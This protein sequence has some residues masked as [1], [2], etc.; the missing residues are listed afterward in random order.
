MLKSDVALTGGGQTIYELAATAT[1]AAAIEIA[2]NQRRNAE[3]FSKRN[4][5]SLV[6]R[7]DERDVIEKAVDAIAT[8]AADRETR[9]AMGTTGRRLVDGRGAERVAQRIAEQIGTA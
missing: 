4:A 5:L 9:V 7:A 3:E 1:P 6:G 8:L 2:P